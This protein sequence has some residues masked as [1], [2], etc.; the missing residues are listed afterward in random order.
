MTLADGAIA[1]SKILNVKKTVEKKNQTY[2]STA[3]QT[4]TNTIRLLFRRTQI[5]FDCCSDKHKH[6]ST[7]VQT[8]NLINKFSSK[9]SAKFK[10]STVATVHLH[11]NAQLNQAGKESP[12]NI[13]CEACRSLS[14]VTVLSITLFFSC[15]E[16]FISEPKYCIKLTKHI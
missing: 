10:T 5:Q 9:L 16:F 7:A 4:N 2:N 11:L 14:T 13:V 6:N 1:T 15:F 3:V 12:I 8:N